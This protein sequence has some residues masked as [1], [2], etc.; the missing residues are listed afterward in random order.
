M[1]FSVRYYNGFQ[2]SIFHIKYD[3]KNEN[4]LTDT[5]KSCF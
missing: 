5:K 1:V 2:Q 4:D 3:P